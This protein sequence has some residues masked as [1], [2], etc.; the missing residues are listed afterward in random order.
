MVCDWVKE[1]GV[2]KASTMTPFMR[3]T[4]RRKEVFTTLMVI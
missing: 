4:N 2:E 1:F 3:L